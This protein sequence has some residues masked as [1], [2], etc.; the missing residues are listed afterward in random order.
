[1]DFDALLSDKG[2]RIQERWIQATLQTYPA[3][4][5][6]FLKG[7]K[8]RFANPVGYTLAKEIRGLFGHLLKGSAATEVVP[9]LDRIIRIRAIQDFSASQATGFIFFLKTIIREELGQDLREGRTYDALLQLE[10]RID[11]LAL[12]AFDLYMKCREKIYE[13]RANQAKNQVSGLLR[14]AGL[15]CEIPPVEPPPEGHR[16]L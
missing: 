16:D 3:D 1:M 13:I 5:Q 6:R 14:R 11:E 15:V 8:D 9:A 12:L 4:S 7:Q 10:S 2:A